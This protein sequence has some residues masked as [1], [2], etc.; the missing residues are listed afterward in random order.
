MA[1]AQKV[2]SATG[3]TDLRRQDINSQ[4]E[5]LAGNAVHD[6]FPH[7]GNRG[8]VYEGLPQLWRSWPHNGFSC[9]K[10]TD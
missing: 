2:R 4:A 1:A 7:S 3:A 8:S 6:A 9:W 5:L 10:L